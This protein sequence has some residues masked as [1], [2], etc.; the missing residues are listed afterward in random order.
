MK[1]VY[2]KY[3]M[4]CACILLSLDTKKSLIMLKLNSMPWIQHDEHYRLV[5]GGN[6]GLGYCCDD[7]GIGAGRTG[8]VDEGGSGRGRCAGEVCTSGSGR[9]AGDCGTIEVCLTGEEAQLDFG[10]KNG[11]GGDGSLGFCK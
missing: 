4:V 2:N 10:G 1:K 8:V 3:D 6:D 9:W 7:D 5:L 11:G